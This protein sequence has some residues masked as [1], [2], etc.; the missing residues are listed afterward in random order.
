MLDTLEDF[1]FTATI[2]AIR[3]WMDKRHPNFYELVASKKDFIAE[4]AKFSKALFRQ[5]PEFCAM[6]LNTKT[7]TQDLSDVVGVYPKNVEDV[8]VQQSYFPSAEYRQK[9]TKQGYWRDSEDFVLTEDETLEA[10][11][12]HNQDDSWLIASFIFADMLQKYM[13]YMV[14]FASKG[15]LK[16]MQKYFG[17]YN[18]SFDVLTDIEGQSASSDPITHEL[19]P[20][21]SYSIAQNSGIDEKTIAKSLCQMFRAKAMQNNEGKHCPFGPALGELSSCVLGYDDGGQVILS[22]ERRPGAFIF[23]LYQWAEKYQGLLLPNNQPNEVA[24]Q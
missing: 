6:Y 21:L 17:D 1:D 23:F 10:L 13:E 24:P 18:E 12:F 19:W 16:G 5:L 2:E 22:E 9:R 4:R 3:P 20:I 7:Y 8:L 11:Q 14:S 15:H